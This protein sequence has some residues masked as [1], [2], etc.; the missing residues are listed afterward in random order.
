M[1]KTIWRM[2]LT[3]FCSQ[4]WT[5][6][7]PRLQLLLPTRWQVLP[8]EEKKLLVEKRLAELVQLKNRASDERLR[9]DLEKRS[10]QLRLKLRGLKTSQRLGEL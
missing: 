1:R 9:G 8:V 5:P 4:R 6:G 3:V 10:Q 2:N 7:R